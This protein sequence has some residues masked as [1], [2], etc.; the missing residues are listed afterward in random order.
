MDGRRKRSSPQAPLTTVEKIA[1]AHTGGCCRQSG[2]EDDG[3]DEETASTRFIPSVRPHLMNLEKGTESHV[4]WL[5]KVPSN[6]Y[7]RNCKPTI[8]C[9]EWTDRRDQALKKGSIWA[10]KLHGIGGDRCL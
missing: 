2:V 3:K 5:L 10:R 9:R 8:T 1:F 4:H 6:Q 7:N